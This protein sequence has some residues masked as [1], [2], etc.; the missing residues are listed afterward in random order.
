[1]YVRRIGSLRYPY[2]SQ[3]LLTGTIQRHKVS[4]AKVCHKTL[5]DANHSCDPPLNPYYELS[6]RTVAPLFK[7]N[8][9]PTHPLTAIPA[10]ATSQRLFYR[11]CPLFTP[12]SS[13]LV[14][15]LPIVFWQLKK[16]LYWYF[17]P[18]TRAFLLYGI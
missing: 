18:C 13:S 7:D 9:L 2:H 3:L 8:G 11:G 16:L 12:A 14:L 10:T 1:M 6:D 4:T 15:A 17:P 5:Y